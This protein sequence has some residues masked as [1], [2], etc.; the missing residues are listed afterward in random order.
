MLSFQDRCNQLYFWVQERERIRTLKDSGVPPPWTQDHKLATFRF[1]NV[2]REDDRVTRWLMANTLCYHEGYY[3]PV[4][5][6]LG[7]WINQPKTLQKIIDE[8]LLPYDEYPEFNKIRD[9]MNDLKPPVFNPAYVIPNA[10]VKTPKTNFV[11]NYAL[12]QVADRIQE[13]HEHL[14]SMRR[15]SVWFASLNGWAGFMS[16]QVVVD[17]SYTPIMKYAP[18]LMDFCLP[19]PGTRAGMAYL[20]GST[21]P[22]KKEQS[23]L[24]HIRKLIHE[25]TGMYLSLSNV[26]NVMCEYDKYTRDNDPK[27]K[28]HLRED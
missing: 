10:G 24:K 21:V 20:F 11:C 28:Y 9:L 3:F 26:G 13:C 25:N 12:R 14:T 6:A 2:R 7:R 15:A 23:A 4:T 1:C 17:I 5:A 8:G 19:G 18:D 16:N 27:Q 22:T